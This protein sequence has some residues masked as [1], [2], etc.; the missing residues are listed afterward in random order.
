ML[1]APHRWATPDF[2][3]ARPGQSPTRKSLM[4]RTR[5]DQWIRRIRSAQQPVSRL[6]L[7]PPGIR[8]RCAGAGRGPR[9][10]SNDGLTV[11]WRAGPRITGRRPGAVARRSR[12]AGVRRRFAPHQLRHAHAVEMSREGVPLLLIERQLG[13]AD[14]GT[15]RCTCAGSTTPRSSTPSTSAR[16]R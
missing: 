1:P 6:L 12:P 11:L 7:R 10:V 15:S 8:R 5:R 14:S 13:H 2:G 3:D 9:R 4:S 16:H